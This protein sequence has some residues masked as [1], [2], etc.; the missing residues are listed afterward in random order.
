MLSPSVCNF[1]GTMRS[2][3]VLLGIV[4]F[5]IISLP[6]YLIMKLIGVFSK[7]A[8]AAGSQAI[9]SRA[10]RFVLFLAGA[11]LTKIG[12]ENIPTDRPVLYTSNHRSY[13]DIPMA[14][15]SVPNLVG[16]VAKKEIRK[17]PGLA[18]WMTNMNC[19]FIDREDL[20]QSLKCILT[21]CD[22]VKAGY[23]MFI[24]PE[25]TRNHA[26]DMLPFKE[27][28]FKIAEKTDCP[29]IPVAILNSDELYELH[30]PWIRKAHVIIHYGKP[31]ETA[32]LSRDE[33]KGLGARVRAE[34][35]KMI[36]EDKKLL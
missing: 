27:G 35:E 32:E 13:A 24:M 9:I 14:Y 21:A 15:S 12:V 25:G 31:I 7:H 11:K 17:V 18:W 4:L 19:L 1:G 33:R 26:E 36:D 34:I 16:F 2:I 22:N 28:S 20:R 8:C 3:I 10:F 23:S 30:K 6:I 5:L 29:I